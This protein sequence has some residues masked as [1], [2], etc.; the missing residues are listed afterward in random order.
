MLTQYL[1]TIRHV[2]RTVL[3]YGVRREI[4]RLSATRSGK[5]IGIAFQKAL[6]GDYTAEEAPIVAR[7]ESLRGRMNG[8]AET[9]VMQDFGAGQH[10]QFSGR[11]AHAGREVNRRIG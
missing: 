1:P 4:T 3:K 7:I 8:S 6:R 10:G 9:F 2:A 5:L 11:D